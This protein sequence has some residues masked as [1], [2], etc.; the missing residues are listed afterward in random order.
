MLTNDIVSFEQLGLAV[1]I[2]DEKMQGA[3]IFVLG[4]CVCFST[5]LSGSF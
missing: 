3:I 2:F 4:I 1:F 5:K